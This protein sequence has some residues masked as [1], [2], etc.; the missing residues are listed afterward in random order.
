MKLFWSVKSQEYDGILTACH[1]I[2]VL[3]HA[4]FTCFIPFRHT[5]MSAIRRVRYHSH[6]LTIS[7]KSSGTMKGKKFWLGGKSAYSEV[8]GSD[9]Q[10]WWWDNFSGMLH[11]DSL[12]TL[13]RLFEWFILLLHHFSPLH[14]I[15]CTS[16]K[17][18]PP[19]HVPSSQLVQLASRIIYIDDIRIV[20]CCQS[21]PNHIYIT[22]DKLTQCCHWSSTTPE[23]MSYHQRA[24]WIIQAYVPSVQLYTP[25]WIMARQLMSKRCWNETRLCNLWTRREAKKGRKFTFHWHRQSGQYAFVDQMQPWHELPLEFETVQMTTL[26]W[27]T[28]ATPLPHSLNQWV[29]HHP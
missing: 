13:C 12:D 10:W 24:F 16:V 4:P 20:H 22:W 25:S 9:P 23:Y 28:W 19:Y 1:T 5:L 15:K 2:S 8:D 17:A 14:W 7:K 3:V 6:L 29:S 21:K 18:E 11:R 26:N 27:S